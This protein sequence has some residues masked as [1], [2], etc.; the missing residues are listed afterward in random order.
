MNNG[1]YGFPNNTQNPLAPITPKNFRTV[2][3]PGA[4]TFIVPEG[5]T[6]LLVM[7]VGA[8][9]GG[10]AS[11][12]GTVL[13]YVSNGGNAGSVVEAFVPVTPG[14]V[15]S[16]TVGAG[17]NG[18]SRTDTGV[19]VAG[20]NGTATTVTNIMTARG[21]GMSGTSSALVPNAIITEGGTV[22]SPPAGASTA[23]VAIGGASPFGS[24]AQ[25]STV[26]TDAGSTGGAGLVGVKAA[27]SSGVFSSGGSGGSYGSIVY[28]VNGNFPQGG[29]VATASVTNMSLGEIIWRREV[30]SG[31]SN[32]STTAT[33]SGSGTA[34]CTSSNVSGANRFNGGVYGGGGS[35]TILMAPPANVSIAPYA[36]DGGFLAGGGG[37]VFVVTN[38]TLVTNGIYVFGGC[39]G[40]GGGG[41]GAAYQQQTTNG[42]AINII[43][44]SGGDGLIVFGWN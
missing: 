21:G 2:V 43:A 10:S 7:A 11:A 20:A 26:H 30:N 37:A 18:G 29:G 41:G 4:G 1:L 42:S 38:N 5:V 35:V 17:G 12:S 15:I 24:V 9:Q 31:G 40:G 3:T 34:G 23:A 32:S 22:A 14:Q 27:T 16:Y 36:G 19:A 8:G 44:G 25:R 33:G 6:K 13:A 39:G 28:G